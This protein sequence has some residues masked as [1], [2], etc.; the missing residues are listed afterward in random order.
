MIEIESRARVVGAYHNFTTGILVTCTK[1]VIVV[2]PNPEGARP[3]PPAKQAAGQLAYDRRGQMGIRIA[4]YEY[5][6]SVAPLHG[7]GNPESQVPGALPEKRSASPSD[8]P[9]LAPTHV[10]PSPRI[11]A[12]SC[13]KP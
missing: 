7:R 8:P 1:P 2:R 10:P 11:S 13:N 4:E 5:R 12:A 3:A 6:T 9:D